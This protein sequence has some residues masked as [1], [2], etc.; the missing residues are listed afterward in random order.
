MPRFFDEANV[1]LFGT[2]MTWCKAI[3]HYVTTLNSLALGDK[4]YRD[5]V[6]FFLDG[7]SPTSLDA[8][9]S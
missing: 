9:K 6:L 3:D 8:L 4:R 5:D 2:A 1:C 7:V